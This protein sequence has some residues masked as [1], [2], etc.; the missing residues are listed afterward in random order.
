MQ[1]RNINAPPQLTSPVHIKKVPFASLSR[2][3]SLHTDYQ[4]IVIAMDLLITQLGSHLPSFL[5]RKGS[6]L[7]PELLLGPKI[8]KAPAR[9]S[10]REAK[11]IER[12]LLSASHTTACVQFILNWR[13]GT[14]L[15]ELATKQPALGKQDTKIFPS[16][17]RSRT[18]G[19][20][21]S[22]WALSS[23]VMGCLLHRTEACGKEY[24]GTSES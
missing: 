7:L 9:R 12:Q 10:R 15:A 8:P 5:P 16:Y 14:F 6:N 21:S 1:Q 23:T 2:L 19:I 11:G 3:Y 24:Q 13:H 22:W 18:L 17:R 4:C 20:L